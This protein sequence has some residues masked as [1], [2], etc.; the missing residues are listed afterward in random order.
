M[1]SW[2]TWPTPP[3]GFTSAQ[4]SG[5]GPV[6]FID[7]NGRAYPI[8]ASPENSLVETLIRL[9]PTGTD[10]G[11]EVLPVPYAWGELFQSGPVLS[12][13]AAQSSLTVIEE[14]EG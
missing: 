1:S 13:A 6:R 3:S 4:A 11:P 2:A 9:F 8:V 14:P 7:E 12:V 10:Q 5:A